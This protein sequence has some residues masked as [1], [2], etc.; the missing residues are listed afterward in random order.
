MSHIESLEP[1]KLASLTAA[2][3]NKARSNKT[4]TG[5][6]LGLQNAKEGQVIMHFP[7]EP[8]GYLHI[9]H[10]KAMM[11]DQYFAKMYNGKMIICFDDTNC[12]NEQAEF[13]E[14]VLQDL[15]LLKISETINP[16]TSIL[17]PSLHPANLIDRHATL[18]VAHAIFSEPR[19]HSD[20]A[21]ANTR[22]KEDQDELITSADSD[23]CDGLVDS[24]NLPLQ[25]LML[26]GRG[27][28]LSV[29]VP[30]LLVTDSHNI[31]PLLCSAL[32]QRH[33]WGISQPVVSLCYSRTGTIA[34]A[35]FRWLKS[36]Q[37]EEGHMPRVHLTLAADVCSDP[38]MGVF[39]F[40]NTSSATSLVQF[41]LGLRTHFEDIK[42]ATSIEA[43]DSLTPLHWRSN[44]YD[45][46]TQFWGQSDEQVASWANQ[47]H[48]QMSS[49]KASSSTPHTTPS[50]LLDTALAMSSPLLPTIAKDEQVH[51]TNIQ[52][53]L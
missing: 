26:L 23:L 52:S 42:G 24:L 5:F 34:T 48:M 53:I 44:V 22:N 4:A 37:S 21:R 16:Q 15:E 7:P 41:V 8:S 49:S 12:T 3:A 38:L 28:C 18:L 9:D 45:S 40:T 31:I 13:V 47:V 6:A 17:Q 20:R 11:L 14:T 10:A 46:E 29:M 30:V 36:D 51:G 27:R 50:P 32:Y 2:K 33:M 19:T 43:V 25:E 35:I 39:D 1:S